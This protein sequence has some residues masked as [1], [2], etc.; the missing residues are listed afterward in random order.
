VSDEEHDA[1]LA[2]WLSQHVLCTKSLQV[3]KRFIIMANQIHKGQQFGF[4]RLL[5]GC[6]YESMR[7]TCENIKKTGDGF[8]FL[9]YGPFWLL[10]LWLNATFP[11]ELDLLLPTMH[12]GESSK[13]QIEGTRLA[14]MVQGQEVSAMT[15]HSSSTSR[16]FSTLRNSSLASPLS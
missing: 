2:L 7:S 12:Y 3:A 13:R 9:G 14:L 4:A 10:Q 11:S 1:F 6:L 16:L 5:L 15:K 8:T